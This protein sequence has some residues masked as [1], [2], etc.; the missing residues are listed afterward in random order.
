MFNH[1]DICLINNEA[2]QMLADWGISEL[3]TTFFEKYVAKITIKP[4]NVGNL[5]ASLVFANIKNSKSF[6]TLYF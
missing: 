3:L 1:V 4:K 5:K 2:E 6:L